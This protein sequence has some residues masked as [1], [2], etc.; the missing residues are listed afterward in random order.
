MI[1]QL[2]TRRS[3]HVLDEIGGEAGFTSDNVC[4]VLLQASRL[5]MRTRTVFGAWGCVIA[6]AGC[7]EARYI[8]APL[9]GCKESYILACQPHTA[10]LQVCTCPAAG[11][12]SRAGWWTLSTTPPF[13]RTPTML[14][15][16]LGTSQLQGFV[17]GWL[18]EALDHD[19][20]RRMIKAYMA[21][22]FSG[23]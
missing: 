21:L 2:P 1:D 23:V 5:M 14:S 17:P 19:T 9:S 13:M 12:P 6:G 11:L 7:T 15:T 3:V 4:H 20:L 10:L 8:A 16:V 18:V 22:P